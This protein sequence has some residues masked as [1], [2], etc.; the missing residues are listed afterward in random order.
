VLERA[1]GT[2]RAD[3]TALD[4]F[5]LAGLLDELAEVYQQLGR[6]D[7]AVETMRAAIDAGYTGSP[8]PR[9]RIAEIL[10][11]AGRTEPAHDLYAQVQNRHPRGCVALQQR[12]AGIRRRR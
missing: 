12:R 4:W 10:L 7:D 8:D 9:C 3:P 11:R 6:V 1:I 5:D 2:C